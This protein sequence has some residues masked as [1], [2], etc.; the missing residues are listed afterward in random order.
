MPGGWRAHQLGHASPW[1][2]KHGRQARCR[3]V[4]IVYNLAASATSS[5]AAL[6][7]P[8]TR[9]P[10]QRRAQQGQRLARACGQQDYALQQVCVAYKQSVLVTV[11]CL[12]PL[13]RP[14][15]SNGPLTRR[16]AAPT[17]GRLQQRVVPALQRRDHLAHEAELHAVGLVRELHLAAADG[18]V[19][20]H[21]GTRASSSCCRLAA[22]GSLPLGVASGAV[23]PGAAYRSDMYRVGRPG[24]GAGGRQGARH[25]YSS[26]AVSRPLGGCLHADQV[27]LRTLRIAWSH[28]FTSRLLGLLSGAMQ[29]LGAALGGASLRCINRH[30][31]PAVSARRHP[32]SSARQY[33]DLPLRPAAPV[34]GPPDCAS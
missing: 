5:P 17:C 7:R 21:G 8:S 29:G 1:S 3:T 6:R 13:L 14:R 2:L 33:A 18:V 24:R 31:H 27:T 10:R 11:R 23:P 30:R 32:A 4:N 20:G 9:L 15:P 22:G 25:K 26:G 28:F 12:M 16:P 34:C 19:G